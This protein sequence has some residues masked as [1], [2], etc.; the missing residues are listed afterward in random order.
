M[1]RETRELLE[2]ALKLPREDR[3]R[4]ADA[5]EASLD[6]EDAPADPAVR[7]AWREEIARRLREYDEGKAQVIPAD[8]VHAEALAAIERARARRN[9]RRS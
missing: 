6:E 1:T 8:Q 4:L 5:L 9:A 7:A 2:R 3:A